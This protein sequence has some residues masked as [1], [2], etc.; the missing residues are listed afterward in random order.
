MRHLGL[1]GIALLLLGEALVTDEVGCLCIISVIFWHCSFCSHVYIYV[2]AC[3]CPGIWVC[4]GSFS[5]PLTPPNGRQSRRR[6]QLRRWVRPLQMPCKRGH[7]RCSSWSAVW[8]P[9]AAPCRASSC[10]RA[11]SSW[12]SAPLCS[13]TAACGSRCHAE[14]LLLLLLYF[15]YSFFTCYLFFFRIFSF[16]TYGALFNKDFV[17]V[18]FFRLLLCLISL[19]ALIGFISSSCVNV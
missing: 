3:R 6:H 14:I 11:W 13:E 7:P 8:V 15:F 9:A 17:M 18:S 4:R 16:Y 1:Q 19:L 5:G 10:R 2:N 12:N